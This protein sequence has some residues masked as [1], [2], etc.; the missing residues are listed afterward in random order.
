[1]LCNGESALRHDL[2]YIK[3][4]MTKTQAVTKI[5]T[6]SRALR[7]HPQRVTLELRRHDLTK[8]D[9]GN[10]IKRTPSK[11]NPG[12]LTLETLNNINHNND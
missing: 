6:T 4:T 3:R 11:S 9:N 7:E 12:D 10:V 5:N 1:M 8:I 2:N